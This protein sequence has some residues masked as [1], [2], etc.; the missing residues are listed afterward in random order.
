MPALH[1]VRIIKGPS[2]LTAS[3]ITQKI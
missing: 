1:Q 3:F 2:D